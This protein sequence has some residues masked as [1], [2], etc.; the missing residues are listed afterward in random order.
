MKWFWMPYFLKIDPKLY[1]MFYNPYIFDWLQQG[2]LTNT[3]ST[4]DSQTIRRCGVVICLNM[5]AND[6]P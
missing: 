6:N 1:T 2:Y 5:Y 3:D 4:L